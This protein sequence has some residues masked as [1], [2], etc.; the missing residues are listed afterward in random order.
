MKSKILIF[1][2]GVCIAAGLAAQTPADSIVIV[3]TPWEIS[4]LNKG[5]VCKEYSF[6]SLYGVPLHVAMLEVGPGYK[7]DVL[8]NAPMEATSV[9]ARASG[10]LAAINGSFFNMQ[11]GNSVCY[12]QHKG[13]VIDTTVVAYL[14]RETAAGAVRFCK[15]QVGL[16]PWNRQ[17]EK[18]W[19]VDDCSVLVSGPLL[20]ADKK[21][22]RL[23]ALNESFN[24]TRHPRSAMAVMK[25]G[26][27][28]LLTVD[29]RLQ[30]KSEGI[31][32]AELA[33]LLRVLGATDAINLDGGGST[34][35][36]AASAP[37]SGVLNHPSGNNAF[38]Q[39]GERK[40]ANLICVYE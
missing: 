12:L 26:T 3:Q 13:A 4:N 19:T 6:A 29:G 21:E 40:V 33:H 23:S 30:G 18:T 22:C 8:I 39:L 1:V 36:W 25:D 15:E 27:I 24:Q 11:A 38:D 16:L 5:I 10:A 32:L 17:V 31:R 7:F 14:E 35:L 20:L 2:F 37:G 34:T 9:S 28:L